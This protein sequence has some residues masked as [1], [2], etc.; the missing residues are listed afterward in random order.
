MLYVSFLR[1]PFEKYRVVSS[2]DGEEEGVGVCSLAEC[3]KTYMTDY[4]QTLP[5][6]ASAA[7]CGNPSKIRQVENKVL[8]N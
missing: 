3:Q 5:L 8:K 6:I 4:Q 1:I 7:K 2:M